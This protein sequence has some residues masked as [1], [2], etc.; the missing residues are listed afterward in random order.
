MPA[1][2][3]NIHFMHGSG[4]SVHASEFGFER[5]AENA[6]YDSDD[7]SISSYQ[8]GWFISYIDILTLLLTLF[9]ILLAMTNFKTDNASLQQLTANLTV[10]EPQKPKQAQ[11]PGAVEQAPGLV[12]LTGENNP[13]KP[14]EKEMLA[15]A[16]NINPVIIPAEEQRV[17]ESGQ[18]QT[19]LMHVAGNVANLLNHP[20]SELE[21][22]D[23]EDLRQDRAPVDLPVTHGISSAN[24]FKT[25]IDVAKIFPV[26]PVLPEAGHDVEKAH[27]PES[28]EPVSGATW[29]ANQD[30]LDGPMTEGQGAALLQ[31]I[32]DS[33]LGQM[34]EISE[35]QGQ[36]NL[37]ISEHIL[38]APGNADL[39]PEGLE[40]LSQLAGMI[41]NTDLNLS[42][43]G[44]TDNVPINNTHFPSNWELSTAR[45]TMVTRH[46]IE[47]DIAP[48]RIRAIG[49]ADT[50][51]RAENSSAVGRERNR[52]VSIVLHMPETDRRQA[53]LA[54]ISSR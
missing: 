42:V 18:A 34:I 30:P 9:V 7:T 38:F 40:L 24:L 19:D 20:D 3:K 31:H 15:P 5:F 47:N 44:H 46:L 36:V 27:V 1:S 26:Q 29:V 32:S 41:K 48:D 51:P 53:T 12:A 54:A 2:A 21:R 8:E 17:A 43:E 52:R 39:K 22:V 25:Q 45:A 10:A 16:E 6:G 49:Y 11:P 33:R 50:H 14:G 4:A 13:E 23:R 35:A 28:A 37:E